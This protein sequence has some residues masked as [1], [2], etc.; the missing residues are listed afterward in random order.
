MESKESSQ[1]QIKKKKKNRT[2]FLCLVEK[3][4]YCNF[5]LYNMTTSLLPTEIY[6]TFFLYFPYQ[7]TQKF[8]W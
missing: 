7:I 5:I 8:I 3:L 1:D 4:L 6:R 2:Q